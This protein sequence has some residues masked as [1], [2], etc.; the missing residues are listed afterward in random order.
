MV[1]NLAFFSRPYGLIKSPTFIFFG[2]FSM[3]HGQ[4][5]TVCTFCLVRFFFNIVISLCMIFFSHKFFSKFSCPSVILF[6]KI[7]RSYV[8]YGLQSKWYIPK[9]NPFDFLRGSDHTMIQHTY[10]FDERSSPSFCKQVLKSLRNI[11]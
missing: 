7:F 2:I 4:A 1:I 5:N 10:I 6:S 3:T 8:Y 9:T 11:L